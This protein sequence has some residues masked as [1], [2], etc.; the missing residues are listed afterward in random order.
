[1]SRPV[2]DAATLVQAAANY[3]DAELLPTLEGY[4]RFQT[5]VVVHA[6]RIVVRELQLGPAHRAEA[7]ARLAT[8]LGHDGDADAL[9]TELAAALVDGT[10]PLDD[11]ALVEHLRQTLQDALAIHNPKWAGAP[12]P[13]RTP[14]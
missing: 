2:P 7:H 10:R 3:L 13:A 1:M 14:A 12:D 5:R 4:H 11:P 9:E 6:L 8:L